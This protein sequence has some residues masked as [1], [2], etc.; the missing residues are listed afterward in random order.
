[1]GSRYRGPRWTRSTPSGVP[2]ASN[3]ARAGCARESGWFSRDRSPK[4]SPLWGN[5]LTG[6]RA[7]DAAHIGL[8]DRGSGQ[9]AL[10]RHAER[11]QRLG[12]PGRAHR[13]D[14]NT[15]GRLERGRSG[16]ALEARI[17]EANHAAAARRLLGQ[18]AACNGDRP[19]VG[20]RAESIP[21]QVD[22]THEFVV[23]AETEIGIREFIE[24]FE[25]SLT[26]S[27]YHGP[28][29]AGLRVQAADGC[30]VGYVDV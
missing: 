8:G 7:F 28:D 23:E 17:H 2:P 5:D 19:A 3:A 6:L 1:M 9:A 21:N 11:L 24:G 18:N 12:N 16:K 15:A 20:E 14:P 10:E 4:E 13:V 26:C 25:A 27:A 30:R 29:L 22:L